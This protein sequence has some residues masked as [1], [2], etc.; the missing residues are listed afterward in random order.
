ML[1]VMP[2]DFPP[3]RR[4]LS[5]HPACERG[6]VVDFTVQVRRASAKRLELEFQLR[7]DP[8]SLEVPRPRAPARA[9]GLWHHTC[10]EV[11]VSRGQLEYREYNF[12]PS[13]AW[14]AYRFKNYRSGMAALDETP[15]EARWRVDDDS[16]GLNVALESDWFAG[17]TP[18][19]LLRLG[20]SSVIESRSGALSYW[21]LR[22]PSEKPDFHDAAAFIVELR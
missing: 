10:F 22:H 3:A 18:G 11:F 17:D 16:L 7:A 12:A 20:C 13:G 14:A 19:G 15:C 8:D 4:A 9:D 6:G 21:A 5:P 1:V 2:N